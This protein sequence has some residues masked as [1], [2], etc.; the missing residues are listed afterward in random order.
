[1]L[2]LEIPDPEIQMQESPENRTELEICRKDRWRFQF[3][4]ESMLDRGQRLISDALS[5]VMHSDS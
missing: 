4:S 3:G 1:M 2:C 5:L